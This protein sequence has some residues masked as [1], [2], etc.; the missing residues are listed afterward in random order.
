MLL[1][2]VVVVVDVAAVAAAAVANVCLLL[3]LLLLLLSLMSSFAVVAAAAAAAAAFSLPPSLPHLCVSLRQN[4]PLVRP[5][6]EVRHGP[7]VRVLLV[8]L[9]VVVAAED[10]ADL[11]AERVVGQGEALP[12]HADGPGKKKNIGAKKKCF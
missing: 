12:R 9:P 5:R 8:D 3:L 4:G 7:R 6:H 10:V 1:F 11:V 2:A